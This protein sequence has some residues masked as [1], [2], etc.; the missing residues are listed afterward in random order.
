MFDSQQQVALVQ[1]FFLQSLL[2]E[3]KQE[4]A[5]NEKKHKPAAR[6]A[7]ASPS[8]SANE[9]RKRESSPWPEHRRFWHRRHWPK[10]NHRSREVDESEREGA[11]VVF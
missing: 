2:N 7:P 8:A 4:R 6:F 1:L 10:A 11:P 5:M 3:Q 9:A